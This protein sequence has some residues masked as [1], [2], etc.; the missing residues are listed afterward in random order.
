MGTNPKKSTFEKAKHE[1]AKKKF[2]V[3]TK[4]ADKTRP[5]TMAPTKAPTHKGYKIVKR[6]QKRKAA[7]ATLAFPITAAEA[8]NPVMQDALTTGVANSLGKDPADVKITSIDGVAVSRR[9]LAA[10]SEIEF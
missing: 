2:K 4:I 7:K 10:D 3:V 8:K 9:R 5:P 1:K 6:K